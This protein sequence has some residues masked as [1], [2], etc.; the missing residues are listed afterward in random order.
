MKTT[1]LSFSLFFIWFQLNA[2][3]IVG[4]SP[5]NKNALIEEFTGIGCGFCPYGHLEVTNFINAHPGDGFSVAIHQGYF[6]IPEPPMP[7]YRTGF[8]DGLGEYFSVSSWPNGLINRHDHGGGMLYPLNEWVQYASGVLNESSYVNIAC[9][10]SVDVQ[11]RALTVHV[12]TYYTGNSPASTNFLNVVLTQNN[13]KGPQFSSWFNPDAITPDGAYMHQHMLR[14]MITGQ[15]GE[16]IS[17][18]SSGTFIDKTYT[19]TVPESIN[20]ILLRLGDLEI[21]SFIAE[22]EEE[23]QTVSGCFAALDNFAYAVD[24]GID[25]VLLPES[26]CSNI[27]A[28]IVLGNYGSQD[29]TSASFEM[30]I[31]SESV[32][33]FNWSGEAISPFT[34]KEIAIPAVYFESAGT[35]E[36]FINVVSVNGNTDEN[37]ANNTASAQFNEAPEVSKPVVLH[38]TTD[39]YFGTAWYLYDGQN[40]LIQMGSGYDYQTTYDIDLD[41]DAGCYKFVM[42][43]LDGFFFGSY[44]LSDGSGTTFF[45][46]NGNFGNEEVVSFSLPIYEPTADINASTTVAC[47]GASIQFMDA[48]TGGPDQWEW[49]FEGGDPATSNERN[50][51]VSYAQP[52]T[53]DVSLSVSN[54]LGSDEITIED[55][56]SVTSLEY[57]NLALE[58]DGINDY[59]RVN[60]ESAYDIANEITLEAWIKPNSLSGTQG[61]MTKEFGNNAHP[62]QIRLVDDEILFGFY[63]N[64]IGWQPTQT[65]NAN[66]QVGEWTHIAC[67][68]NMQNVKIYV[69]GEL[70]AN[71]AKSFEIPQNDQAF[72]IGRTKDVD[73]EY[74]DGTIDEVRVWDIALD[75]ATI[76]D[77]MCTN[78]VGAN[79]ENL[80]GYFKFNECGG[81]VLTDVQ[82]GN[83]GLLINMEGDEWVESDACAVYNVHFVITEDAG[84]NPVEDARV[85]MNATIRYTDDNGLADYMGYETGIYYYSVTKDG[86]EAASGDFEIIDQDVTIDIDILYTAAEEVSSLGWQL[87][88]NPASECLNIK[89]DMAG[90]M[91]MIDISG[92]PVFKSTLHKGLNTISVKNQKPGLYYLI[93][94]KED[95]IQLQ[96]VVIE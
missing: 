14:D 91:E 51:V 38:L 61:V 89:T 84:A 8:G 24:A 68:Y 60:N 1:L 11:T 65:T 47:I 77:N 35:Q 58:F 13:I 37:E 21:I 63:S 88:P 76:S 74:F 56:I 34:A 15:W 7:D 55:Y 67:T 52:G 75:E 41:V 26:S 42:T 73:Y 69:N 18:T 83:D 5:E 70:K 4:T 22:T 50:P 30:H 44:S 59:V 79:T 28:K 27:A 72:E 40:N 3:T 29:I 19:Y 81:T 82:N 33:T 10:A 16:E 45:S 49:T 62:Y 64:T 12:E 57:G 86:Y 92:R 54:V 85:N 32:E 2:Q 43:D 96:K 46:R 93:I 95:A 36:Y 94:K 87:Y 23:V 78:Y 53:Y 71:S 90:E 25:E 9:E 6:A 48:S 80:I 66:L 20:D 39:N 17:P 31:G